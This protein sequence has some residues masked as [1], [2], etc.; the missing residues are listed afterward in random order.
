MSGAPPAATEPPAAGAVT[1]VLMRSPVSGVVVFMSWSAISMPRSSEGSRLVLLAQVVPH[2]DGGDVHQD[3]DDQQEH[4]G[5][6]DHRLRGLH[7]RALEADV[8]DVE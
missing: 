7:V 3:D 2:R 1:S 4:R 8:V 5:R 6:V